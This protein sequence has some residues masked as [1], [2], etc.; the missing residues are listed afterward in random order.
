MS[1]S[2][3]T[4]THNS[5]PLPALYSTGGV[6]WCTCTITQLHSYG[7]V[8]YGS[9]WGFVMRSLLCPYILVSL[10]I[11]ELVCIDCASAYRIA[12]PISKRKG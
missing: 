8:Q 11:V 2:R 10:S 1:E 4:A 6:R 7:E 5:L 3:F 12:A 9:D